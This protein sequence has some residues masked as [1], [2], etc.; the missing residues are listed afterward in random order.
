M[1]WINDNCRGCKICL[2]VCMF[3]AIKFENRKAVIDE[4]ECVLCGHCLN[5]I[6]PFEAIRRDEEKVI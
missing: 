1:P 6:C 4:K 2:R 5:D 3:K